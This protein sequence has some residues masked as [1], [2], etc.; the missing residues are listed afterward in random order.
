MSDQEEKTMKL[1]DEQ[2]QVL[3]ESLPEETKEEVV[4]AVKNE[5][6]PRLCYPHVKKDN[7]RV[8][9]TPVDGNFKNPVL[10]YD[11][12]M[13]I[14]LTQGQGTV[15]EC[16]DSMERSAFIGASDEEREVIKKIIA[17]MK[18]NAVAQSG[19]SPDPKALSI[20]ITL[21]FKKF[22]ITITFGW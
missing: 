18:T 22:S 7:V 17:E 14:D 4:K 3:L 20:S 1:S 9:V 16:L 15:Y 11:C 6:A 13:S 10:A 8:V 12:S 2:V 5:I 19:G 21:K